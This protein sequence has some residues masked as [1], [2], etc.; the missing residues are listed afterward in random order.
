MTTGSSDAG[1]TTGT[2]QTSTV[3]GS[4]STSSA[5]GSAGVGSTVALG[6]YEQDGDTSDGAEPIEW[7]VLAVEGGRALLI[8]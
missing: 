2:S 6:S 1:S 3:S 4:S 8:S 5:S 7:R